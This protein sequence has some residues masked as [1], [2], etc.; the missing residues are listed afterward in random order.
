MV[1][2]VNAMALVPLVS[3]EGSMDV[4]PVI[5]ALD[6][7]QEKV[8]DAGAGQFAQPKIQFEGAEPDAP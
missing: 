6:D 7:S 8:G 4:V 2:P 1:A 5:A 3:P